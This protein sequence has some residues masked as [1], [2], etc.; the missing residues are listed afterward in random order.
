MS[1]VDFEGNVRK[2]ESDGRT[3]VTLWASWCAPCLEELAAFAGEA[4]AFQEKGLRVVALST[5][6]LVEGD[7][8]ADLQS[9]K[10]FVA[11]K[12]YPFD[13][14]VI[15]AAGMQE[16]SAVHYQT[17]AVQ[18]P[19]ALPSS[20]LTDASGRI[21][22]LYTGAVGV[23]HLLEDVELMG[24]TRSVIEGEAFPFP[25][26]NGVEHFT[27]TH[28]AF[29]QAFHSGGD[30]DAARDYLTEQLSTRESSLKELYFLGTVE[31][32]QGDGRLQQRST[33]KCSP[34]LLIKLRFVCRWEL[35]CGILETMPRPDHISKSLKD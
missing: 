13:F 8:K 19:L 21:G 12:G 22:V 11:E 31:Q 30:S 17:F 18:R 32:S 33:S 7:A 26:R 9:A 10:A 28:L 34:V 4:K 6:A 25:G 29:A 14:G 20:F 1:Y 23:D 2:L 16:L 3:L 35:P 27:L 24:A 15:D 5:D